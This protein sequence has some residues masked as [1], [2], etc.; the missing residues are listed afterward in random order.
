MVNDTVPEVQEEAS[1]GGND[2]A[3]TEEGHKAAVS[4]DR[5]P[6]KKVE[7]VEKD[8][9]VKTEAPSERFSLSD[10]K[11][12]AENARL[13]D[14]KEAKG[15]SVTG[16]AHT[17]QDTESSCKSRCRTFSDGS[18]FEKIQGGIVS[19]IQ[20]SLS[21]LCLGG[22]LQKDHGGAEWKCTAPIFGCNSMLRKIRTFSPERSLQQFPESLTS[23]RFV[24][25]T[26]KCS[27]NAPKASE[28]PRKQVECPF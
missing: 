28:P 27:S 4:C 8:D 20:N 22:L 21:Q 11:I 2:T 16:A 25:V 3:L 23:T 26:P 9:F 14:V 17:K 1:V 13:R 6:I 5:N 24:P 19:S 10:D 15:S 18:Q 12:D 7:Q